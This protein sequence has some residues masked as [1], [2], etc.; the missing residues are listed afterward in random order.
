VYLEHRALA[1]LEAMEPD[2]TGTMWSGGAPAHAARAPWWVLSW[3]WTLLAI[4]WLKLSTIMVCLPPATNTQS[5]Y[6]DRCI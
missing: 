4:I 2:R 3:S 5:L 1:G 6:A